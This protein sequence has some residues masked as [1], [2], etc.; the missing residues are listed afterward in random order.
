MTRK[1]NKKSERLTKAAIIGASFAACF[2]AVSSSRISGVFADTIGNGT[3]NADTGYVTCD[4]GYTWEESSQTCQ[5]VVPEETVCEDGYE[6]S[7]ETESCAAPVFITVS[8]D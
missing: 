1:T 2:L 8:A 3:R 6:Y 5:I 4:N 7:A